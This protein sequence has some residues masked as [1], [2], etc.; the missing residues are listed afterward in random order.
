MVFYFTLSSD[1]SVICY[2]GR[3]KYEN[4]FLIKFG[5]P[6]DFWFHVDNHSSAHVY[7]RLPK[8]KTIADLTDAMVEECCQLTK[9]NSIEG[10][11]LNDVKVVYTPWSNLKKTN[12]MDDGQVGFHS[13]KL[14]MY[15]TV[16]KKNTTIL[17]KLEK[18]RVEKNDV[19]FRALR[20]ARDAEERRTEKGDKLK[21][22]A[23]EAK[24]QEEL[25]K[26][27]DLLHYRGLH[28]DKN[29]SHAPISED[30]FM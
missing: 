10:C 26:A 9:A 1:P 5:W 22:A 23:E 14:R 27:D 13:E 7:V 17:N 4:E 8:G 15:F 19:D 25:K 6:E 16:A 12:G 29:L 24:K 3:D 20:E 2:M 30:D 11:K 28:T 18:T 21:A